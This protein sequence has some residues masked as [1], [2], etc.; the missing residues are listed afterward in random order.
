MSFTSDNLSMLTS[1]A[2][3]GISATPAV[4]VG[5]SGLSPVLPPSAS[6]SISAGGGSPAAR[7]CI[8]A[9]SSAH[10]KQEYCISMLKKGTRAE[11]GA[12]QG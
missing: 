12:E 3:A 2:C 10:Y 9:A 5:S 11:S 1:A 4:A 7:D 6:A 8:L